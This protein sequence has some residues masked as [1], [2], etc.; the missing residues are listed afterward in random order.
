MLRE[1]IFDG[2]VIIAMN[3]GL[4]AATEFRNKVLEECGYVASV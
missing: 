3:Y 4:N 1:R 2:S